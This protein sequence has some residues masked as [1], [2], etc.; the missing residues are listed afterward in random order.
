M[1]PKKD[2]PQ[3]IKT[4]VDK[5][6]NGIS[7]TF[8]DL[9]LIL[10]YL[11]T[12]NG[13]PW[14]RAQTHQSITV[15]LIEEAY[16][17]VDAIEKNSTEKMTEETG[18]VLLQSVFHAVI[19][20]ENGTF[21]V[22]DMING[23]CVKLL[24]RHTH[25]FGSDTASDENGALS[26]WEKNKYAE[27]SLTTAGQRVSDVP[28]VFPALLRAEKVLKRASKFGEKS[29]NLNEQITTLLEN[30]E[31]AENKQETAGKLLLKVVELL[32]SYGVESETALKG[33]TQD[34]IAKFLLAEQKINADGLDITK[35]NENELKRYFNDDKTR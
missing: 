8:E 32:S 16:E 7:F 35:L 25:I 30:I 24:T 1:I 29:D 11:R 5:L 14:D 23:E 10:R 15:D 31:T 22:Q 6:S 12:P 17:L 4:I 3:E 18:D 9:V 21:T 27:K 13:C 19:G 20:E 28:A 26:V 33:A 34:F 2:L